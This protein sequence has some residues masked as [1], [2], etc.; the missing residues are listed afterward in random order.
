MIPA[1]H[2]TSWDVRKEISSQ[3]ETH[4]MG[5]NLNT[6]IASEAEE[7]LRDEL[8]GT[9]RS[10]SALIACFECGG[11]ETRSSFSS[12]VSECVYCPRAG[13]PYITVYMMCA[14]HVG[15]EPVS[16]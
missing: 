16:E 11:R 8:V 13:V 5:T 10:G 12:F 4:I 6:S 15:H 9:P 2:E 3:G 7:A 14:C 1:G